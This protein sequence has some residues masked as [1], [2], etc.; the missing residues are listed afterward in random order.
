MLFYKDN[1]F[2]HESSNAF[3]I[4]LFPIKKSLIFPNITNNSAQNTIETVCISNKK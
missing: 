4:N 2:I 1:I 3:V